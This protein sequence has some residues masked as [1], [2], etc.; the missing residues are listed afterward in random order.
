MKNVFF[1]FVV[2]V[3][4]LEV[5]DIDDSPGK[6]H[7]KRVIHEQIPQTIQHVAVPDVDRFPSG[8]RRK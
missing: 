6:H 2:V 7:D 4:S 3:Y 5:Q 8:K 1:F